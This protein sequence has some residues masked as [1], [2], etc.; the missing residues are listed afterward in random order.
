MRVLNRRKLRLAQLEI[1]PVT[2]EP[3]VGDCLECPPQPLVVLQGDDDPFDYLSFAGYL[4]HQV[5]HVAKRLADNHIA[6]TSALE[7]DDENAAV[8]LAHGQDVDRTCI[9]GVLLTNDLA[10]LFED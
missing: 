8:V 9:S 10:I 4:I 6:G 2:E 7:F 5:A 3:D 1:E